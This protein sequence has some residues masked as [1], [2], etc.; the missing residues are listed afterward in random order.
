[1]P[2][3]P[4]LKL[5]TSLF[6]C[7]QLFRRLRREFCSQGPLPLPFFGRSAKGGV[8]RNGEEASES[9]THGFAL[10]GRNPNEIETFLL[11]TM[12]AIAGGWVLAGRVWC[13]QVRRRLLQDT[14]CWSLSG[15]EI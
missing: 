9:G 15:M 1:V 5:V 10:L 13:E 11:V 8:S 4:G 7:Y 14:K 12:L 6:R 3:Q 2:P